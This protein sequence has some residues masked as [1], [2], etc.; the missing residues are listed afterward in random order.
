MASHVD[1]VL[2]GINTRRYLQFL[3]SACR[4]WLL[5]R[6]CTLLVA[7]GAYTI[8]TSSSTLVASINFQTFPMLHGVNALTRL[9]QIARLLVTPMHI[10]AVGLTCCDLLR[11]DAS[12]VISLLLTRLQAAAI[13]ICH[14]RCLVTLLSM[15]GNAHPII[16]SRNASYLPYLMT[17]AVGS[18]PFWYLYLYSINKS[19]STKTAL[20]LPVHHDKNLPPKQASMLR[21]CAVVFLRP[22]TRYLS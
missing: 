21:L 13:S 17:I 4:K 8:A 10:L 6:F 7:T 16:F 5:S 11:A 19:F 20:Y 15:L 12:S 14:K 2:L 3:A 1:L 18:V 22:Y 9:P